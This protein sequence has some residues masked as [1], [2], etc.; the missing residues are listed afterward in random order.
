[1]VESEN[2]PT[3]SVRDTTN[4]LVGRLRAANSYVYLTADHGDN[5]NSSRIVFQVDG[6]SSAYVTNG[7][8][9]AETSVQF[10]TYGSGSET[11]TAA[12]A[13]AVDS[14][15]NV[16]E[17]AVQGSPTGGSGTAGKLTK[18]DTSSTL[19]DS[20]ITESSGNIGIGTTAPIDELHVEGVIQSKKQLLPS[21]GSTAGWYKIGTLEGFVQG[22][23]TAV[24]E[25]AGHQGYNATNSQDY[26]IKL[27]IKTSNGNAGGPNGQGFN[28]WYERTGGNS[29]TIEFKW[30]NSATNDY[31][32][33]M[34]IPTHSLRSL[35]S[36]KKGTGNSV[37]Q[38][39]IEDFI[40]FLKTN[41]EDDTT[42]F[43]DL[44]HFIW[45]DGTLD[46]KGD[47][48][49]RISASKYKNTFPLKVKNIQ[50]YFDKH[51]KDLLVR[52]IITGAISNK[53]A[54]YLFFGDIN[55]CYVVSDDDM[56]NFA[57]NV[58]KRPI[59]IG[60]LTFQAWNRN[61]NGGNKSEKKRGQIQ[62]KWGGLKE[63]I[64][65]I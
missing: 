54:D 26:L 60:V 46:G 51:K 37:H 29:A 40:V 49:N 24:I 5:V 30:D 58:N 31:D 34:F 14:S 15:G 42:V 33:Y 27:F 50:D 45:G 41:F 47:I 3:V 48:L 11:G 56:I 13:L 64:K 55:D 28:S 52:F 22:G 6:D 44:R 16:I 62:L 63:N 21:T 35:Y 20:V 65:Q 4:S 2:T 61:I 7:L 59:S 19:T 18:W 12:Y 25:I 32:L 17:T 1:M 39:P 9:A 38:E 23:A 43:N 10:T 53:K 8:F 36:V 57:L